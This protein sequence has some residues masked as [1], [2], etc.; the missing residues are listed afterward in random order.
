M[1]PRQGRDLP[2]RLRKFGW[3]RPAGLWNFEKY[4]IL[5]ST[6]AP[7]PSG[8]AGDFDSP[9]VGSTPAGAT[10]Q[11]TCTKAEIQQIVQ[12]FL[13]AKTGMGDGIGTVPP[14]KAFGRRGVLLHLSGRKPLSLPSACGCHEIDHLK[15]PACPVYHAG[16]ILYIKTVSLRR[17]KPPGF[18]TGRQWRRKIA[19]EM[20]ISVL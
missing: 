3:N 5:F 17:K 13:C 15:C 6:D 18:C 4:A 12:V 7:S 2:A 9:I 14:R 11:K 8:K 19:K 20:K 10:A 16:F 1:R